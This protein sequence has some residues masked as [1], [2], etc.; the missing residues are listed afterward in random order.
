MVSG[1]RAQ[2]LMQLNEFEEAEAEATRGVHLLCEWGTNWDKRMPFN[3]W[4]NW[5]RCLALQ[6]SMREWPTTHG[7][8]ESLGAT[9]P[10]MRFRQ[11]N[12]Q[13]SMS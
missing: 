2:C 7:G 5:S 12:E 13:R 4:L 10:R 1:E 3:A 9:L 8:I 6:A 11:L